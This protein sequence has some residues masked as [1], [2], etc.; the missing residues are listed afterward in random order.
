MV[1]HDPAVPAVSAPGVLGWRLIL[2]DGTGDGTA[3]RPCDGATNMA[4]DQA[5]LTAVAAGVEPVLRLYRWS[6]ATLSFGRN[7]PARGLYDTAAAAAR[8]FDFVRRPTG[9]QAVL[10]DDELTYAVVAP[11][12]VVGRP[13]AAYRWINQA[14][15]RG[16]RELGVEASVAGGAG[17]G[18]A[19]PARSWTEACFQRPERGEL[20]VGGRKLVGSA[21]RTESHT[22]LQHGS[23][24]VGGTQ[25]AAEDLLLVSPARSPGSEVEA[26]AALPGWTTLEAE[27]GRR[28]L[29]ESLIAAVT[30][31]FSAA[32]G[33]S[34]APST[35]SS[36]ES[37][38]TEE[39]RPRFASQEWTW[40]R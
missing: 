21:Q 13:R 7:Q 12:A 18:A 17:G 31:G 4:V 1:E 25:A 39:L 36:E 33:T 2:G 29:M 3:I 15:V 23:I 32:L 24:L 26:G 30:S 19:G 16:I 5:L 28:P 27:L 8:G 38:A 37:G 11:V 9:G 35:L 14:L 6:P 22:I 10:H 20:V 34:L 40:R